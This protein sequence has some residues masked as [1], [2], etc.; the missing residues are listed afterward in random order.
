MSASETRVPVSTDTRR[1]L[2]L[3]KAHEE[4]HSYDDAIAVLLDAYERSDGKTK[5]E[6]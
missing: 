1:E 4:R 2:R 6:S 3:V 5:P